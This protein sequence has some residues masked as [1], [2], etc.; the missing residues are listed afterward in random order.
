MQVL[1]RLYPPER[2]HHL[3]ALVACPVMSRLHW[4]QRHQLLLWLLCR[5]RLLLRRPIGKSLVV[6]EEDL[7]YLTDTVLP[8]RF[9]SRCILIAEQRFLLLLLQLVRSVEEVIAPAIVL[10]GQLLGRRYG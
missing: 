6:D 1:D 9:K 7:V 3:A 10:E 4:L 5:L 8:F 2:A